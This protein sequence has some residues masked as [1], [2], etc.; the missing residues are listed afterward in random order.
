M[1]ALRTELERA[2]RELPE[3]ALED[4]VTV[5]LGRFGRL[6]LVRRNGTWQV[7]DLTRDGMAGEAREQ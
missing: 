7:G 2:A 1:E 4:R 6:V 5:S 3:Q